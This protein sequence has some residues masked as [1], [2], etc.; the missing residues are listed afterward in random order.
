[1]VSAIA[2]TV[3]DL[4]AI[5]PRSAS[6]VAPSPEVAPTPDIKTHTGKSIRKS[7]GSNNSAA[8]APLVAMLMSHV[9][10]VMTPAV[11]G[12]HLGLSSQYVRTASFRAKTPSTGPGVLEIKQ[13]HQRD[14][15]LTCHQVVQDICQEFFVQ[16]T[17]IFSGQKSNLRRLL[18]EKKELRLRFVASYP[19]LLRDK[20][21]SH[22]ELLVPTSAQSKV[23]T[24]L[25]ASTLAATWAAQQAGFDALQG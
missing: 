18:K 11:F 1:V 20:A 23:Y 2:E 16:E 25:Q 7:L 21:V 6:V 8:A 4:H 12:A 19:Q 15:K 10:P 13:Q 9:Q 22:P 24:K 5:K 3:A 17:S 14:G